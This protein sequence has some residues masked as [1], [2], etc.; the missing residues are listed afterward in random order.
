LR[1]LRQKGGMGLAAPQLGELQRVVA[2]ASHPNARYPY[3][4][5]MAPMVLINPVVQEQSTE[6]VKD[7]EG[8]LSVPGL[9]GLV[10][11]ASWVTVTYQDRQGQTQTVTYEG[12]V[13]RIFQHEFDHLEGR[14]FV[15][16]VE[17]PLELMTDRE[18]AARVV[19]AGS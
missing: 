15:D 3:A 7:W 5:K 4:P 6:W 10:P 16:R 11:R 9:R 2:I 1:V 19:V 13:A 17:S 8:C 12:F 18:F 14:V